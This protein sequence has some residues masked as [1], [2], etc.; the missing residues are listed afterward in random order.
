MHVEN[1]KKPILYSEN[2]KFLIELIIFENDLSFGKIVPENLLFPFGSSTDIH[3]WCT[4]VN[5]KC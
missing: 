1:E 4:Y 2:K 5:E 3:A